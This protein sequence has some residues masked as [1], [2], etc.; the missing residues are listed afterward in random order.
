MLCLA[1]TS[2]FARS[3]PKIQV[4]TGTINTSYWGNPAPNPDPRYPRFISN[5]H[6]G[7]LIASRIVGYTVPLVEIV[8]SI[9]DGGP[10]SS[11]GN[12]TAIKLFVYL[13]S[14][15]EV[16]GL[17]SGEQWGTW[18]TYF[19]S[20]RR[21]LPERDQ[22]IPI[23]KLRDYD[24][25]QAFRALPALS[26]PWYVIFLRME[27]LEAH[28]TV[29]I[30]FFGNPVMDRCKMVLR[31]PDG[32]WLVHGEPRSRCGSNRLPANVSFPQTFLLDDA[33]NN[34]SS[35][36]NLPLPTGGTDAPQVALPVQDLDGFNETDGD[37]E[38]VATS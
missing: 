6:C 13:Q 7:L 8:T 38:Q 33:N 17:Y 5:I 29:P 37:F 26:G 9:P 19:S 10:S 24:Q 30:W 34:V 14:T 20:G 31:N 23:W 25:W 16:A 21:F 12:F 27:A 36:S 32:S 28:G 15:G 11:V 22:I 2:I 35:S 18:N 4:N 3:E 1:S